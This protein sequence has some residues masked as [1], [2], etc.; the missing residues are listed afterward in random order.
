MNEKLT[1]EDWYL[2]DEGAYEVCICG[3]SWVCRSCNNTNRFET[4]EIGKVFTCEKC[5]VQYEN[6]VEIDW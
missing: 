2:E 6:T 3:T 5:G 4:P 1:R